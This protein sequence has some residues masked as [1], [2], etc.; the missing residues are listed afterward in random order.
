[1]SDFLVR[2]EFHRGLVIGLMKLLAV[3]SYSATRAYRL[4]LLYL[5]E[6]RVLRTRIFENHIVFNRVSNFKVGRNYVI[7]GWLTSNN[8]IIEVSD[9]S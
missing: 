7:V 5:Q 6:N 4:E 8:H 2:D 1:M 3:H 9:M